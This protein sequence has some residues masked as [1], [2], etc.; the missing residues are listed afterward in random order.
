MFL[1]S[2]PLAAI[3]GSYWLISETGGFSEW[4]LVDFIAPALFCLVLLYP[5][6]LGLQKLIKFL[7]RKPDLTVD[8]N[9]LTENMFIGSNRFIPWSAIS[10][11]QKGTILELDEA[12]RSMNQALAR[13]NPDLL[14]VG[15]I[16]VTISDPRYYNKASFFS[17]FGMVVPKDFFVINPRFLRPENIDIYD[18]LLSYHSRY[19][20]NSERE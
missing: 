17:Y 10:G 7:L 16:K 14:K 6:K 3:L 1:I 13:N 20:T 9:G 19:H 15:G 5:V 2:F 11:I 18:L 8:K 4:R 12:N